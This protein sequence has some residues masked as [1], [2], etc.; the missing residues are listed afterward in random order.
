MIKCES[1]RVYVHFRLI[2]DTVKSAHFVQ[3]SNLIK[4]LR[5]ISPKNPLEIEKNNLSPS[6]SQPK[7]Y[8]TW[9]YEQNLFFGC[10]RDILKIFDFWAH[11]L[12]NFN[13]CLIN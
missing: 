13:V 12:L 5:I 3:L 1:L 4:S 6:K 10:C 2:N 8:L 11:S 9:E 7:S